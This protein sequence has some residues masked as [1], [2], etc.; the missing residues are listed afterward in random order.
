M[1]T[2]SQGQWYLKGGIKE[3]QNNNKL[4]LTQNW[5]ETCYPD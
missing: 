4:H 5:F 1:L 3:K 2:F